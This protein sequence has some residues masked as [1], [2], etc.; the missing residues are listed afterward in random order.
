MKPQERDLIVLVGGPE[1]VRKAVGGLLFV[2]PLR[3]Q[4]VVTPPDPLTTRTEPLL[5]LVGQ[6]EALARPGALLAWLDRLAE[7][8]GA[9]AALLLPRTGQSWC[10][11][12]AHPQFC[13]LL[14]SDPDLAVEDMERVLHSAR[15]VSSRRWGRR[16]TRSGRFHFSLP[17]SEAADTER[18]WLLVETVLTGLLGPLPELARV[19]MAFSEVLTNSVEHGNLELGSGLKDEPPDGMLRFFEERARRLRDPRYR[20]RR[21]QV[22]VALRGSQL[23]IRVRNEGASFDFAAMQT[24][25]RPGLG[26]SPYGLGLAMIRSLVDGIGV[27]EEGRCLTLTHRLRRA[28]S[29]DGVE[30]RPRRRPAA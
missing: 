30:S 28:D 18:V 14:P 25:D 8:E 10:G 19:G 20:R 24:P 15:R 17:T 6:C 29:A 23:K 16:V 27:S 9:P 7:V 2:P 11:A 4:A 1:R 26:S 13:G 3:V 12:T 21:V 22:Q 5:Y